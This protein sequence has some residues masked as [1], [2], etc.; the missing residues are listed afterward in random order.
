LET[1]VDDIRDTKAGALHRPYAPQLGAYSLLRRSNGGVVRGLYI[2][3]IER[4]VKTNPQPPVMSE[5]YNIDTCE[6]AAWATIQR[7]KSDYL[8]FQET[9]DPWSFVA[10]PMSLMCSERYCPAHGTKFCDM[11][12]KKGDKK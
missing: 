3:W 7:I 12:L 10:N 8:K 6:R 1:T 2:D 4:E 11:Y 5:Q 9:A